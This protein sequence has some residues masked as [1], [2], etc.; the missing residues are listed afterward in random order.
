[1]IWMQ[2]N[3]WRRRQ[4][5]DTGAMHGGEYTAEVRRTLATFI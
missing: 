2:Q 4:A 5:I 3:A 1:M